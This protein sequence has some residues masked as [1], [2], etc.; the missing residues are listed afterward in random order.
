VPSYIPLGTLKR[1]WLCAEAV[2]WRSTRST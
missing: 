2:T 1:Y